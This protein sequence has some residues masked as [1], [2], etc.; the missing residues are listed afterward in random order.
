MT[1]YGVCSKSRGG[2]WA[3]EQL[4]ALQTCKKERKGLPAWVAAEHVISLNAVEE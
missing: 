4:V 2:P 1:Q 3:S